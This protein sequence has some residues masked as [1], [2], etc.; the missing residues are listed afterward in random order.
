MSQ[1]KTLFLSLVCLVI[2]ASLY[3]AQPILP[4]LAADFHTSL[5]NIGLFMTLTF[6]GNGIAQVMVIPLAD[7]YERR[8]LSQAML[9]LGTISNLMMACAASVQAAMAAG[10]LIGFPVVPIC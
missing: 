3:A 8:K 5:S 7:K 4:V 2:T 1:K 9:I 6:L 10:L